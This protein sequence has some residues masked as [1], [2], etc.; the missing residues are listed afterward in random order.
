[1]AALNNG[2]AQTLLRYWVS[3]DVVV[4][5]WRDE[6]GEVLRSKYTTSEHQCAG[7]QPDKTYFDVDLLDGPPAIDLEADVFDILTRY[8]SGAIAKLCAGS[9]S[10]AA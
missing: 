7:M 10:E 5:E 4:V 9:L 6:H 1:M 2:G 3:G 8:E